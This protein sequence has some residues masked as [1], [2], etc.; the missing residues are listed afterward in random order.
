MNQKLPDV[1]A[2]FRKGRGTR[3]QSAK[4]YWIIGKTKK[5]QKSIYFCLIDETK[6]FD[7]VDHSKLENSLKKE[8]E[9]C[10][11]QTALLAS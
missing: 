7:C 11:Y 9:R 3:D 6:A 5:F 4:T 8:R 1:Q 2:M 10:E